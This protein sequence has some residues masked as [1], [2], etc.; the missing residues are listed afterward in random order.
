ML[1]SFGKSL[2]KLRID[3]DELLKDMACKLGVTVSYLSAVEIGRR[4]VPDA[5][6]SIIAEE[7]NLDDKQV[8]ELQNE[9]MMSKRTIKLQLYDL[10][11]EH[12]RIVISFARRYRELNKEE[13]R[14]IQEIVAGR[15]ND[16]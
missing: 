3:N 15:R 1:T 14:Q 12:K 4:E 7:Y 2:R 16:N 6:I 10:D 13:I 11:E 8:Q 9:A 5:W